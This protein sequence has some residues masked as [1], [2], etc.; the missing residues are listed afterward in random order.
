LSADTT[1]PALATY[2]KEADATRA[3]I[4]TITSATTLAP[5][6]NKVQLIKDGA[7]EYIVIMTWTR[8]EPEVPTKTK[9]ETGI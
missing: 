4:A 9:Q 8:G 5:H 3:F 6:I 2:K 7:R 1:A